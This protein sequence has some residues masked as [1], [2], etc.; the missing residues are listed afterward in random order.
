MSKIKIEK[1][2]MQDKKI[3]I[4]LDK[5]GNVSGVTV[6]IEMPDGKLAKIDPFGRVVWRKLQGVCDEK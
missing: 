1:P 3:K 6:H 5:G 2:T 4:L